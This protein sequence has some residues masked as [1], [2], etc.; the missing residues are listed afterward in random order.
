MHACQIAKYWPIK[1]F[2]HFD[3]KIQN[4]CGSV[5]FKQLLRSN[6]GIID[7]GQSADGHGQIFFLIF[8]LILGLSLNFQTNTLLN[9]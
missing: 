9:G 1:I 5:L 4:Y 7:V 6:I 8:F 2:D 3:F